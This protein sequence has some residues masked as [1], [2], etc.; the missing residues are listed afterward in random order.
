MRQEDVEFKASLG[1]LASLG[2][3]LKKQNSVTAINKIKQKTQNTK[4]KQL[5]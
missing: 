2:L 4:K 5:T 1:Y 3:C